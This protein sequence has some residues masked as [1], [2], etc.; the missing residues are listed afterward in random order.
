MNRAWEMGMIDAP[1]I[2][3]LFS[4]RGKKVFISGATSGFGLVVAASFARAGADVTIAGRRDARQ[5]ADEIGARYAQLDVR[6][7]EAFER[8]LRQTHEHT[9]PLDVLILN[10]GVSGEGYL[11]KGEFEDWNRLIDTNLRGMVY[12]IRFG[13]PQIRDGGSIIMTASIAGKRG[14]PRQ[15]VYSA[16]K[17]AIVGLARVA[18]IELGPR[19]IRIN[20][21]C[22]AAIISEP[23]GRYSHEAY[24]LVTQF[25]RA[26]GPKEM[27]GAYAFL[28]SDASS[29]VTGSTVEVDG[30][31]LAGMS[32]TLVG[33]AAEKLGVLDGEG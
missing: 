12:G 6:D 21:V 8:A 24:A 17:E 22:P 26:A 11:T 5:E 33:V 25:D 7:P 19:R 15:G 14:M 4:L 20:A 13:A 9:G 29:W 30:G 18:A 32:A 16:T 31:M 1:S 3:E 27:V 23:G 2:E 28:A 10:Q